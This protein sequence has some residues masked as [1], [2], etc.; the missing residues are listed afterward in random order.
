MC[1]RRSWGLHG[2]ALVAW[3]CAAK[4]AHAQNAGVAPP[5]IVAS[6]SILADLAREIA[7]ADALVSSLVGPDADAHSFE[8]N[9]AHARTLRLADVIV[10]NG[11][12]F[13]GSIDR[14]I[15]ASKPSGV[16][17]VASDGIDALG[18]DP[19]AW[20]DPACVKRYASNLAAAFAARWPDRRDAILARRRDFE[21]RLD[22]LDGELRLAV[23]RIPPAQRRAI[24]SHDAFAYLGRAYGITLLAPQG[25]STVSEPSAAAVARMIRQIRDQGARAVF[26]ENVSD[27]RLAQRIAR[28]GGARLGGKL[29]SDALSAPGGGASTYLE[30]MRANVTTLVTGL[31]PLAR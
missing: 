20:Q 3:S 1:T 16:V 4:A 23:Q 27:P 28:E 6:F 24:V 26:V 2:A 21:V 5:R 29:Y 13:E 19:H 17:V 10:V 25:W 7:P 22:A 31:H 11:L 8:P 14:L 18:K 12:G 9:P 15:K 30:M